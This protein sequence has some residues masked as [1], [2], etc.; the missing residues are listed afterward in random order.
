MDMNMQDQFFNFVQENNIKKVKLLL[1]NKNIDPSSHGNFAIQ[2]ASLKGYTEMV[3][4]LISNN[5]TDPSDNQNYSI[6]FAFK[7]E[8][9][10]IVNLLWKDQR[11]KDTLQKDDIELY[12]ELI[13]KDQIK[14]KV[15]IF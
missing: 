4:L 11:V 8:Y 14:N 12:N 6:R 9:F 13:K 3:G 7:K 1:N 10:N 2:F 5:R 15:K